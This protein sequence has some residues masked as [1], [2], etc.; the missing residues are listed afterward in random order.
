MKKLIILA[1]IVFGAFKVYSDRGADELSRVAGS[2]EEVIMYSLT[3]CGFCKQKARELRQEG[4]AFTEYYIDKDVKRRKELNSKLSQ[5]GY[6]PKS[7]GTPIMDVHGVV[8]PNNPS[9]TEIKQAMLSQ[10]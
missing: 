5:A 4:I 1:L 8:M 6:K 2:H 7:Y 3:T 9:L 10:R